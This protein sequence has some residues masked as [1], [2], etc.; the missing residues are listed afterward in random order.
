VFQWFV[1][2]NMMRVE[3]SLSA[4]VVAVRPG[5]G[6]TDNLHLSWTQD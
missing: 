1:T 6:G 3:S 4:A 2:V 5:H